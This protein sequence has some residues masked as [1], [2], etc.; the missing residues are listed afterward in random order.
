LY[1]YETWFLTQS[2][3]IH[4]GEVLEQNAKVEQFDLKRWSQTVNNYIIIII[5][6]V[7]FMV[8]FH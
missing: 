8:G 6:I 5:I 2:K 7:C 4:I 1:G 3:V